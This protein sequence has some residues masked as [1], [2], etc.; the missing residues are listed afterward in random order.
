MT[1]KRKP[2]IQTYE[3]RRWRMDGFNACLD[4]F[5]KCPEQFANLAAER[6]AET[7]GQKPE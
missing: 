6:L 1:T 3:Q 4:F 5:N 2:K 7:K